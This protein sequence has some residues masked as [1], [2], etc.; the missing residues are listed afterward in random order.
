[1]GRVEE[2]GW[3]GARAEEDGWP[4]DVSLGPG[5][6]LPLEKK[7]DRSDRSYSRV[8]VLSYRAEAWHN[9]RSLTCLVTQR[10]QTGNVLYNTTST[11]F[12]LVA[13]L[14]PP[15]PPAA[16]L[17]GSIGLIVGLAVAGLVLLVL[18]VLL[19]VC[20]VRRRR[21]KKATGDEPDVAATGPAE[22]KGGGPGRGPGAWLRLTSALRPP[23]RGGGRPRGSRPSQARRTTLSPIPGS[24]QS[25]GSRPASAS[26]QGSIKGSRSSLASSQLNQHAPQLP[27]LG[28]HTSINTQQ[29]EVNMAPGREHPPSYT[30]ALGRAD[31]TASLDETEML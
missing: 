2:Q 17:G 18:L 5:R 12:L 3:P 29:S 16:E 25:G 19:V 22:R 6:D 24:V 1:V 15:L 11:I 27:N 14:P 23:G 13:P 8:S 10:D 31:S 7:F 4:Q 20:L 28:S 21:R 26:L 30:A 9:N